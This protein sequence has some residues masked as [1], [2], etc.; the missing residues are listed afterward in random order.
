MLA[1]EIWCGVVWF[2]LS[3]LELI[4]PTSLL[5][6]VS[7][8]SFRQKKK[9]QLCLAFSG[10][11]RKMKKLHPFMEAAEVPRSLGLLLHDES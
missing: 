10:S 3:P 6:L 1:M 7:L 5:E 8:A 11:S 4:N 9:E 2:C